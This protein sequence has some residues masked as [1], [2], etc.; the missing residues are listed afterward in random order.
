MTETLGRHGRNVSQYIAQ[1]NTIYLENELLPDPF[2]IDITD[3]SAFINED[4]IGCDAGSMVF[5]P[6]DS[7]LDFDYVHAEQSSHIHTRRSSVSRGGPQLKIDDFTLA[8]GECL[9]RLWHLCVLFPILSSVLSRPSLL[10]AFLPHCP[11]RVWLA[12][13]VD[14]AEWPVLHYRSHIYRHFAASQR[15]RMYFLSCILGPIT[16]AVSP[17]AGQRISILLPERSNC[18]T[19]H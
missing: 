10:R 3:F 8:D 11:T 15:G 17:A 1:L 13:H 7:A 18:L 19:F 4:F 16:L 2:E 9:S 6:D 5:N 12:S 14:P